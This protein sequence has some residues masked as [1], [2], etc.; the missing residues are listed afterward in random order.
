MKKRTAIFS[1]ISLC[2]LPMFL[3]TATKDQSA[4]AQTAP[5]PQLNGYAWDNS[6]DIQRV[7]FMAGFHA[8]FEQGLLTGEVVVAAAAGHANKSK[9]DAA[10]SARNKLYMA[11][12]TKGQK[13]TEGEVLNETTLFYQDFRNAPVCWQDAAQ[14]ATLT[15]EGTAPSDGDLEAIRSEDAKKGCA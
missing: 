14:I 9:V 6:G 2:V 8:G 13:R 5:R 3:A 11:D 15:L 7:V 4:A 10:L 12:T 1:V